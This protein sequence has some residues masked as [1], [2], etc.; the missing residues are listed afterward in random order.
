M[1]PR[2]LRSHAPRAHECVGHPRKVACVIRTELL[3]QPL[4]VRPEGNFGKGRY[5]LRV[6]APKLYAEMA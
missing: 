1:P 5:L 4:A 2:L 3:L 6:I